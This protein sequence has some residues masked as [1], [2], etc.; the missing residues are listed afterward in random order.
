MKEDLLKSI[1]NNG[2][3]ISTVGHWSEDKYK[4]IQYYASEFATSM[5]TKWDARIYI[6]LFAGCGVSKI[7]NTKKILAA[8]P[9]LTMDIKNPFDKYIFCDID[10]EKL[11]A[12]KNRQKKIF[13]GL[14]VEFVSGDV[15]TNVSSILQHIPQPS[16]DNTVLS[17][18]LVDIY[19]LSNLKFNTITQLSKVFVDF[20]VLIPTFM[21]AKRNF[22]R[23]YLKPDN[24]TIDLFLGNPNWRESWEY[25]LK[26]NIKFE[27]FLVREFNQQMKKLDFLTPEPD[28]VFRVKIKDKNVPLY[29]LVFYSRKS[30]GMKFWKNAIK[31][32]SEQYR[33]F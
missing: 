1:S 31:G 24:Q 18:C 4:L 30:L 29:H 21:D 2:M 17:F 11:D 5:K 28:D 15:N 32:T 9:L 8:S 10:N 6:D 33:L 13:P 23:N 12:L 22:Q 16:K 3:A 19:N 7:K 27:N 14:S 25:A 20:L 26:Q